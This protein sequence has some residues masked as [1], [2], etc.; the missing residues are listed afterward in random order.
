MKK[1]NYGAPPP[2]TRREF[3][4]NLFLLAED[5]HRIVESGD[6]D[7]IANFLWASY[8]HIKKIKNHP[9]GRINF[10]TIDEQARLQ[11]NMKKWMEEM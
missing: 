9:N 10:Q 3:E 2:K 5:T 8:K 6:D 1:S 4:H 11:A 7:R